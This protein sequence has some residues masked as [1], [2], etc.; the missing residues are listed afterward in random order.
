MVKSASDVADKWSRRLKASTEDI[1]KGIEG[2][3]ENPMQKAADKSDKWI[4]RLT[5]A[6]TVAKWKKNVGAVTLDEWKRAILNKGLGRISAGVD[7]SRGKFEAFMG[8]LLPHIERGQSGIK[9]MPD[10]TLDDNINRMV[11]FVRHMSE[12]K[13]S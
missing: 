9:N 7:G 5:E 1:R 4:A 12:F 13:K 8:E 6:D 11:S 10:L 2:V 3:T